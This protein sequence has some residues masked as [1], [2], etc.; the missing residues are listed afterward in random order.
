VLTA[1]D[2][3]RLTIR[4]QQHQMTT[5][6]MVDKVKIVTAPNEDSFMHNACS[7][8][9]WFRLAGV[10]YLNITPLPQH[11]ILQSRTTGVVL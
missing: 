2:T 3:N 9:I 4:L 7:S 10:S 11:S 1:S 5:S 8:L 6:M